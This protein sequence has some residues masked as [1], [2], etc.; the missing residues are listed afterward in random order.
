MR[1]AS[2][3]SLAILGVPITGRPTTD[4]TLKYN[5]TNWTFADLASEGSGD[6]GGGTN[7]TTVG[8]IPYVSGSGTLN[9][10]SGQ[11]SWDATHNTLAIGGTPHAA[12]AGR[13]KLYDSGGT[14]SLTQFLDGTYIYSVAS[15]GGVSS[16]SVFSS[17][18]AG[19]YANTAASTPQ[20]RVLSTGSVGIGPNNSS[21]VGT[22][23]VYDATATTG[24]TTLTVRAGSA[25]SSTRLQSWRQIDNTE[26]AYAD[27]QNGSMNAFQFRIG[28][29]SQG[30]YA[31]SG[32]VYPS[33]STILWSTTTNAATGVYGLGLSQSSANNLAI[34]NGSS[35]NYATIGAGGLQMGTDNTYPIGASGSGRPSALFVAGA[36]TFGGNVSVGNSQLFYWA[37]RATIGSPGD[38]IIL[39]QNNAGSDFTSLRFGG[40][41]SSFPALKRSTITLQCRL[42]DDSAYA[43]FVSSNLQRGTGAPESAVTGVVGDLFQRTDGGAATSLYLKESGSGNTGWSPLTAVQKNGVYLQVG[44]TNYLMPGLFP[45][46][47]PTT[48]GMSWLANQGTATAST[49]STGGAL[50]LNFTTGTSGWRVY[51]KSIS[52]FTKVT[53]AIGC[54]GFADGTSSR[55]DLEFCG[56]GLRDSSTGRL[57]LWHT[58]NFSGTTYFGVS[59]FTNATTYSGHERINYLN[60]SLALLYLQVEISGSTA[61]YRISSDGF[62]WETV[63][64]TSSFLGTPDE[65]FVAGQAGSTGDIPMFVYSWKEE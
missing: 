43:P 37:T 51:G 17:T 60:M 5:G 18:F 64:T 38:G 26:F 50:K 54:P 32:S 29:G 61:I 9:Q 57:Q 16:G 10:D 7:L 12:T 23:H 33:T 30:I 62:N 40:S 36:G 45:V 20:L 63:L 3:D 31:S 22:L 24:V 8:A 2:F 1:A 13:F 6:V 28:N 58:Q 27:S 55:A 25:Q 14:N 56:F 41:T 19:I 47:L 59:N 44:A 35:T 39:L 65:V 15:Q 53:V 4:Q 52:G 49:S 21:P 11:L 48:S 34:T 46:T 42:A